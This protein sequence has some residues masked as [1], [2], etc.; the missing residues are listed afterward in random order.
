MKS[1]RPINLI[2]VSILLVFIGACSSPN[3]IK[4]KKSIDALVSAQW[5]QNHLDDTDLVILD[6]TVIVQMDD[7]GGFSQ[8]SGREQYLVGHIPTAGFA[9][10][11]GNLS[12]ES[13]IDYVM[14]TPEQFQKAMSELGVGD[15][16]RVVLY[17]ANNHVWA[18]RLWWM[19]KWSGFDNV[20]VLDGGLEAWKAAGFALTSEIP[21]RAKQSF[22][23]NV[24]PE[25]IASQSEVLSG[26]KNNQVDLIDA[27]PAAHYSGA[28]SMYPRS[29]HIFSASNIPTSDLIDGSGLF[30]PTD[31]LDNILEGTKDHRTITYCGGGVAATSVAYNL[32]RLGYSDIAVYM[33]S[34]N[35]WTASPD[36][37]MA[38][39]DVSE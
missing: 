5:L 18:T 2:I 26:I 13:D 28:F 35:Q 22:T 38:V 9:D 25:L 3:H 32:F 29:G 17:S 12:A 1:P 8:I 15:D 36:N 23:L 11:K 10:L 31:V 27:M 33:G 16:S 24:R 19:L 6:T 4:T 30:K 39:G 20:A 21:N 34:L 14:P 7:S 37:P